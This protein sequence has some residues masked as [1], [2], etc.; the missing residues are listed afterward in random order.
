VLIPWLERNTFKLINTPDVPTFYR[1]NLARA[2]VINL[3]FA[4]MN[5]REKVRNWEAPW[6]LQLEAEYVLIRFRIA[7][8]FT[9]LVENPLH[10]R[11]YNFK[12]ADWPR[13]RNRFK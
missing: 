6:D 10:T 3:A 12:K 2:L 7:T 9:K 1:A 5:M 13:F 11:P 4:T 8:R